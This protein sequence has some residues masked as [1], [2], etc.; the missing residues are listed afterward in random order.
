MENLGD[1]EKRWYIPQEVCFHQKRI[2]CNYLLPHA[3][4]GLQNDPILGE[5]LIS[6]FVKGVAS[7]HG[8][9]IQHVMIS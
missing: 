9:S 8:G 2:K 3:E 5:K 6:S 7:V 4:D 1:L